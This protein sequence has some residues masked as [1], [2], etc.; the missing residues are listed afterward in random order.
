MLDKFWESLGSDLAKRWLDNLFG[1]AFLFWIGGLTLYVVTQGW[2]TVLSTIQKWD[3]TQQGAMLIAALL[4]IVLS[5]I[6]MQTLRFSI[7]RLLEGYWPW[8]INYLGRGILFLRKDGFIRRYSRLRELISKQK[9]LNSS[10]QGELSRLEVWAHRH[11]P[12]ERNLLPTELGNILRAHEQAPERKYG[13]DAVVCWPRLW[14]LLPVSDQENLNT[15]R[16]SLDRYAELWMW[17]SFF[18]V[19]SIITPWVLLIAVSWMMLAYDLAI[20]TA[21]SYGDLLEAAFDLHRFKIYDALFWPR[22]MNSVQEKDAGLR[23]CEFL[24]R[25]TLDKKITFIIP[26]AK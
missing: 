17:G 23:L 24:W 14:G 22:P 2:Q 16:S 19:W 25:G 7:L 18:L 13:L 1:P 9:A 4:V 10:E 6:G 15:A 11:P 20:Q 12:S 3:I 26:K 8:P 21:E 5:S